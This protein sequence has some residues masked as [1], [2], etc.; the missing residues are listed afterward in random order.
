MKSWMLAARAAASISA[1][2]GI[3]LGIEQVGADGIVEQVGLL[4][5]HADLRGQRV[6]RHIAQVVPVDADDALPS[7]RTGAGSG[8]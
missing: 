5:H 7:G 8:R 3:R 6:E 1:W 2:V 4:R